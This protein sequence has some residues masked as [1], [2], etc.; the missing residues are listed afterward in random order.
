ML[1]GATA[2][3]VDGHHLGAAE[4]LAADARARGIPVLLDGGSWKPGLDGLL[5]HVDHAVLSADF[6][7]PD[8]ADDLLD[9]VA[10]LGPRVVAQ[11]AG[12]GPVRVRTVGADGRRSSSVLHPPTVP[13]RRSSTRSGRATCCTARRPP[14]SR[15]GH[16]VLTALADGVA[17]ASES[18]R[19]PGALGWVP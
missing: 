19:H 6:R 17:R 11:S 10:D 14:R 3:L 5:A 16:D 8:G 2:L 1:D 7:L 13:P 15:R 4:V 9:R 18:V 12:A